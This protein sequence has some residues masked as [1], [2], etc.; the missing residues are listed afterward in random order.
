M[1]CVRFCF[2]NPWTRTA[3]PSTEAKSCCLAKGPDEADDGEHKDE[4][5]EEDGGMAESIHPTCLSSTVP[6]TGMG[7]AVAPGVIIISDAVVT[8]TVA[9]LPS[10]LALADAWQ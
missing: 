3:S 4:D 2:A 10:F 5:D 7:T 1:V 8:V 9:V 6:A